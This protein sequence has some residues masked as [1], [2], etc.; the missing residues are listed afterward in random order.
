VAVG[1]VPAL[2]GADAFRGRASLPEAGRGDACRTALVRM[3]NPPRLRAA[4]VGVS[5]PVRCVGDH[6]PKVSPAI[7][8]EIRTPGLSWGVQ[9][10]QEADSRRP[11]A[12]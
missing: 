7:S 5:V 2:S 10:A 9:R 4:D 1:H 11:E 8:E 6:S 12:L 3:S